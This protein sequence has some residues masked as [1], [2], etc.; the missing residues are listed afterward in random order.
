MGS[1]S[2]L[3]ERLGEVR[4]SPNNGHVTTASACLKSAMNGHG[5]LFD[6]YVGAGEEGGWDRQTDFLSGLQ[7]DD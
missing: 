2:D 6:H 1:I 7:I 3:S 5:R 4:S